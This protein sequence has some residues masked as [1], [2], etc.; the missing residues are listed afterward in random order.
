MPAYAGAAVY[1]DA[2]ITIDGTE[3]ANQLTKARLVPDTPIQTVRTLVPDGAVVDVDST[4]WTLELSGFQSIAVTGSGLADALS[5]AAQG[6]HLDVV[7][8][9]KKGAGLRKKTFTIV[10]VPVEFG[11]EQGNF[12]TFDAT[13]PV[14]G[15]PV[16]GT[17]V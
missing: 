14:V 6:E 10:A 4:T 2:S 7:L 12:M 17:A 3:Y 11:G 8:T 16:D 15:E 9:P 5:D 1:R 13:F